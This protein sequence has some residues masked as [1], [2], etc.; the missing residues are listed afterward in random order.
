MA[1]TMTRKR[2]Q[3]TLVRLVQLLANLNGELEFVQ[4]RTQENAEYVQALLSRQKELAGDH[5][6]VCA[7]I[8]QFDPDVDCTLVASSNDWMREYRRRGSSI[9]NEYLRRLPQR[10]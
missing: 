9:E 10:A 6:A 1:I 8:K 3:T 5:A 4:Q 2:T 7:T